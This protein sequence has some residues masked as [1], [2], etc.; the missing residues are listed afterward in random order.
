MTALIYRLVLPRP[1]ERSVHKNASFEPVFFER[2][3]AEAAAEG[4]GLALLH[5]H[6]CGIGWQDMS[7]KDVRAEQGNAGAAFGATQ[8]PFV[9]LTIGGDGGWS[10]RFWVPTAPRIWERQDCATVRA[11]G[12]SLSVTYMDELVPVPVPSEEQ[13]RTVSA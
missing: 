6:P 3:M 11:V 8:R 4:A 1:R 5:S 10:G 2:A 9:G 12:D 13:I 7:H